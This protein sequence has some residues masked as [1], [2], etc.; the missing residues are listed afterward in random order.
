MLA[1]S[2]AAALAQEHTLEE[3]ARLAAFFTILGDT[4]GLFGL[5]EECRG[6]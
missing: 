2:V 6:V 3:R 4:L 5:E 1:V